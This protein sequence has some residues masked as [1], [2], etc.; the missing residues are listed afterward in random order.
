MAVRKR[1]SAATREDILTAARKVL[2]R[3]GSGRLS[4]HSVA[5]EA[6]VNQSLIHYHFRT[7]EGLLLAILEQMNAELLDRQRS[8][9]SREDMS[10]AE[11]WQQAVDFYRVDLASGY[12]RTLL[13]LA[14]HGYSNP[15]VAAQVRALFKGWRVLLT[16]VATQA[17]AALKVDAVDAD[18]VVAMVAAYWWGMETQ[19]LLGVPEQEGHLWATTEKIGLLLG[20]LE[21]RRRSPGGEE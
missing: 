16:E 3:D 1:D 4:T 7:R 8:L 21:A 17:L 18:E 19:H 14:A 20:E 11:K 9:Y 12:V 10:I 13:E 15:A 5:A 2:N 6:S